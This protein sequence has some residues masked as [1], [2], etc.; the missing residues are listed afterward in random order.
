MITATNI[1]K[2]F[3]V[4]K[5]DPGLSGALKS[6]IYPKKHKVT[7]I[8]DISFTINKGEI[9]GYIG[10]NGAGKSTTIKI[11]C[12]ILHPTSGNIVIKGLDPRKKRKQVVQQIGVVFG[13]KTQLYWDIR[14]GESFELIKRIYRISDRMYAQNM[15][16]MNEL[17]Q[18]NELLD[19]PVRQ[20]S[21]GQRMR[22]DLA[23][24]FLHSPPIIFLDEP[25][26]GLDI[27]SKKNIRKFIKNIN[28][29]RK[30]TVILTTHDL[31]D[32]E[33]LCSRLIIINKGKIVEDGALKHIINKITPYR[34]LMIDTM[35][36]AKTFQH[37]NCELI[38]REPDRLYLKF[39]KNKTT[40]SKLISQISRQIRIIDLSVKEPDIEDVIENIYGQSV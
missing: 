10:P 17:L 14:L 32:V 25:T 27:Q 12:G 16:I 23:A 21:L 37:K 39:D 35:E 24:A 4:I 34:V 22:G 13:Q 3:T 38:K 36:A 31:N 20:L 26:I 19:T 30:V 5:K 1:T 28:Q 29:Q 15:G 7:A 18:I 9:I 8:D 6:L 40:A 11:L 33:Q 2:I